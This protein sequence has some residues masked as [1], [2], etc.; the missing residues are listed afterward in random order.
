MKVDE[1]IE[2]LALLPHNSTVIFH[3]N[4]ALVITPIEIVIIDNNG[5]VITQ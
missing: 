3:G 1:L 5:D 4:E 2:T